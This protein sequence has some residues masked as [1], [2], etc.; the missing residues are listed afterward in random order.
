[1]PSLVE[2]VASAVAVLVA[3]LDAAEEAEL[4]QPAS[5]LR[6]RAAADASAMACFAFFM[7]TKPPKICPIGKSLWPLGSGHNGKGNSLSDDCV[8]IQ[9]TLVDNDLSYIVPEIA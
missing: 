3:S 4:P 1:M 6:L 5:M 7:C 9:C 2:V 8:F